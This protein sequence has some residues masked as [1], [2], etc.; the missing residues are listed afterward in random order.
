MTATSTHPS[1]LAADPV[2][3]DGDRILIDEG[4][5]VAP[6]SVS[7]DSVDLAA[8]RLIYDPDTGDVLA[9]GRVMLRRDGYT[10][11][12][13]EV[14][15]N[16]RT[17]EAT[18][19]GAVE[20]TTPD[21]QRLIAPRIELTDRLRKALVDSVRLLLE[22][23]S[24]VAALSANHD[25]ET[26][27]TVLDQAVYS[28]CKVCEGDPDSAP[29]W[30]IKAKKVT[31]DRDKQRIT[32]KNAQ[33]EMFSVPVLWTP[34]FSHPDPTVDRASGFLPL[35]LN[36]RN[37][38]GLTATLPYYQVLSR[39]A[40][41]TLSPTITT[42]EGPVLAAE[43][44]KRLQAGQFRV[45]GSI[46]RPTRRTDDNTPL[47]GRQFRGHIASDGRFHHGSHWQSRYQVNWA[48]DDTFLRRYGFS[49]AD[50]LINDYTLEGFYGRS[51]LSARTLAFQGLRQEDIAGETP[52]A[53]PLLTGQFVTTPDGLGGTLTLT[54]N[55]LALSR[56][57]GTD[58]QRASAAAE[59]ERRWIS[60]G[61]MVLDLSAFSRMDFYNVEDAQDAFGVTFEAEEVTEFRA[62]TRFTGTLSLPL[63]KTL[64]GGATHTL[65]PLLQLTLSP[66]TGAPDRLVNEDSRAFE[67]SPL[68]LFSA[69]RA[70]GYDIWEEGSRATLGLKWRYEGQ[71]LNSR[72]LVGHSVR[73]TGSNQ[74]F[75]PGTGLSGTNS[76]I[77]T[78][79]Q[80]DWG[81]WLT[82]DH[83]LRLDESTLAIRRNEAILG[84]SGKAVG[85][86]F[87]YHK[88]NRN[89]AETGRIDR[90]DR[91]ELRA[92]A[93]WDISNTWRLTGFGIQDLTNG[94]DGVE[95][96]GAIAYHNDCIQLQ[97]E[98]RE[99]FT[100][101]R[102][103][104]PGTS[105]LF[106]I[107]LANLG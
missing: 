99:S 80:M 4:R 101:D 104:D 86:S 63:V 68:N 42:R 32:Y 43:V 21:G 39:S 20:L 74:G 64:E 29:T 51:Y 22:D 85:I 23:G 10:L 11:E 75:A 102:D 19:K 84:L 67:L 52:F 92:D 103:F 95:Y 61:G 24:Q 79:L 55:A 107:K 71:R 78:S 70:S 87:G 49:E 50:T 77:V 47:P 34:Y 66:D 5:Q 6:G 16:D 93:R 90:E 3:L 25:N 8:D 48:S 56:T 69:D 98:V 36:S 54:G 82:L 40:D 81:N 94:S 105:V 106:R 60:G 91:E 76:D 65:E 62:L 59:W 83:D 96:G 73:F 1:A 35:K 18:A 31:H 17:G 100:F 14:R 58:T 7:E 41:L 72:L 12:A 53:L 2:R 57:G 30:A 9:R 45:A 88:L 89:L 46:T 27:I 33:L 15:Y 38:L 44:R 26:G 97:L 28:P 13:G 37:E